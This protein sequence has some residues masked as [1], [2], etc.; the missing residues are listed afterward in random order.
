[1]SSHP[2]YAIVAES[3]FCVSLGPI[4]ISWLSIGP[5]GRSIRASYNGKRLSCTDNGAML[6]LAFGNRVGIVRGHEYYDKFFRGR[7]NDFVI[8]TEG[9]ISPRLALNM[10]IGCSVLGQAY[11]RLNANVEGFVEDMVRPKPN[12]FRSPKAYRR[13]ETMIRGAMSFHSDRSR[14]SNL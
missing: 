1:M 12:P 5:V 3:G 14:M 13:A 4:D 9:S 11:S 10:T 8:N 6:G 7:E 2:G